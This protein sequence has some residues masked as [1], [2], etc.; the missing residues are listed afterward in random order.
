MT[1]HMVVKL[2]ITQERRREREGETER[3]RETE[4][5]RKE[6]KDPERNQSIRAENAPQRNMVGMTEYP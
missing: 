2:Q 3:E 5:K 4:D 6:R 1:K